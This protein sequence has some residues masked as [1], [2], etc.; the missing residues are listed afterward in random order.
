MGQVVNV[1]ENMAAVR[2]DLADVFSTNEAN[3]P[4]FRISQ[5]LTVVVLVCNI[6]LQ[7]Q[8][9]HRARALTIGEVTRGHVDNQNATQPLSLL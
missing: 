4:A 9:W 5:V 2:G 7:S 8:L 6:W 3:R 1:D